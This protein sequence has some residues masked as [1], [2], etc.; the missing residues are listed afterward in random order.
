MILENIILFG[1]WGGGG[2]LFFLTT[3]KLKTGV[4]M[5]KTLFFKTK[6]IFLQKILTF[7]FFETKFVLTLRTRM[8]QMKVEEEETIQVVAER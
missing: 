7:F 8:Q 4:G 3:N 6:L 2:D 5:R 1:F